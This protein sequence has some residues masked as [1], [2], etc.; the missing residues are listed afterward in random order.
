MGLTINRNGIIEILI[1]C[2]YSCDLLFF[3]K[4]LM[5]CKFKNKNVKC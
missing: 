2:T 3:L 4:N 5:I 1:R